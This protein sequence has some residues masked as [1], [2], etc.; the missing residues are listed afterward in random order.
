MVYGD[1]RPYNVA[2]VVA[3]VDAVKAWAEPSRGCSTT[4]PGR[5]SRTSKV[6]AL[7][8]AEVEQLR[9]IQGLRG[10]QATSP[11]SPRTSRTDNGMLTPSLKLKRRKVIETYGTLLERCT[12]KANP[13]GANAAAGVRRP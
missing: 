13:R 12:V 5:S 3:N 8:K 10:G 9:R 2:L 4:T 7:F 6:R 1:N 11:S